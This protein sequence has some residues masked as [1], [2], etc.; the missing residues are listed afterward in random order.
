MELETFF[1]VPEQTRLLFCAVFLGIPLGLCFD[2]LRVLRML[3]PHGKLAVALED[4]AFLLVW[5]G[6]L[7]CF[8]GIFARGEM[9]AYYALGST[10]GFLLYRCTIGTVTVRVLHRIFGVSGRVLR[11][12][13][14]PLFH[15]VVRIYGV[16]KE[17]FGHFAKVSGKVHFFWHLPLIVV[18]KVLYN[19]K[20]KTVKR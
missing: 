17:K 1:T 13:T 16:L 7:L 10:L 2:V 20:R 6:A 4:T 15:G 9:R 19:N 8:A 3:L 11:W 18:R 12:L 5:G 14:T